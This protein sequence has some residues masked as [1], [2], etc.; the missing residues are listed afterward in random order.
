MKVTKI[1]IGRRSFIKSST[2]TTGGIML[3]FNW[4]MSCDMTPQQINALPKEW[5]K[6]NIIDLG[7]RKVTEVDDNKVFK[8][9]D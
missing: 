1:K 6:I 4:L 9:K 2:L 3:G 8:Y 5:F 7:Y